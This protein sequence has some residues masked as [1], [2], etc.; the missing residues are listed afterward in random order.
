[1]NATTETHRYCIERS[2]ESRSNFLLAFRL[3]KPARQRALYAFYTMCRELDDIADGNLPSAEKQKRL[4][5]WREELKACYAGKPTHPATIELV[6]AVHQY[7]IPADVMTDIVDGVEMDLTINRYQT[8]DELYRYLYGVAGAVGIICT[9]IFGCTSFDSLEYAETLGAAFQLTNIMRDVG[10]DFQDGRIYLPLEDFERARYSEEHLTRG[11][12]NQA[13]INLMTFNYDRAQKYYTRAERILPPEDY[14]RLLP[15]RL[16]TTYYSA[17]LRRLKHHDFAIF[18]QRIS[19]P[20]GYK[21]FMLGLY[22][23]QFLWQKWVNARSS[24]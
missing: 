9:R 2:E 13:F 23:P 11:T 7:A 12:Y 14:G 16:M 22:W 20:R 3:L 18:E 5:Q 4:D 19:L 17:I 10:R 1:M 15:A 24:S 8:F 6:D 21:L